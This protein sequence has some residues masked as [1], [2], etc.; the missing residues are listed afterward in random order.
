MRKVIGPCQRKKKAKAYDGDGDAI[1]YWNDHHS[2]R[3]GSERVI[4]EK[5][6]RYHPKYSIAKICLTTKNSPEDLKRFPVTQTSGKDHNRKLI[7]KIRNRNNNNNNT[8]NNPNCG[9]SVPADH[10]VK[11][12]ESENIST[13]TLFENWQICGT[14]K[15][16][17]YQL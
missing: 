6:G 16:R 15:R 10:R 13:W 5:T 7:G 2:L 4:N 9:L 14:W 17:W 3:K 1:C 11:L 8:N 12:K